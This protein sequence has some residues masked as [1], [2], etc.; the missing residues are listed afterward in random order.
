M[1]SKLMKVFGA[2]IVGAAF[3]AGA[4]QGCGGS[5]GTNVADLCDRTCAKTVECAGGFITA[6]QCKAQCTERTMGSGGQRCTNE[7]AL[8]A[9]ANECLAKAD[10][11]AFAECGATAPA[12]Q[13]PSTGTAGTGGTGTG[14][15][16][17][18]AGTG[19]TGTAGSG[20]TGAAGFTFD[21][22]FPFDASGLL[23]AGGS[24]GTTCATACTKADACCTALFGGSSAQCA[25]KSSCDGAGANQATAVAVCNGFLSGS[26]GA[27]A[28][29]A[30]K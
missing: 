7:A 12:C 19:S 10:C 2:M 25:F 27:S 4:T 3:V 15:T 26:Q 30:C 28:P 18:T 21:G 6:A 20:S 22:G 14:G 24:A 8:I 29:A 11:A 23:G 5:S 13:R 16:T 9:K 1:S 17:G